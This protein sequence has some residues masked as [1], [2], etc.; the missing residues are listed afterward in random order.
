VHAYVHVL[1]YLPAQQS[2][3][4]STGTHIY[5]GRYPLSAHMY[6]TYITQTRMSGTDTT[7]LCGAAHSDNLHPP[8]GGTNPSVTRVVHLSPTSG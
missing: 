5:K 4:Y 3:A 2:K 7:L 6:L 8:S 1:F